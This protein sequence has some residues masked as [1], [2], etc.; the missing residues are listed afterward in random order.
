MRKSI[1]SLLKVVYTLIFTLRFFAM[2][3]ENPIK[4][5]KYLTKKLYVHRTYILYFLDIFSPFKV[6]IF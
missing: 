5:Y 3:L 6:E 2:Y 1:E 4:R